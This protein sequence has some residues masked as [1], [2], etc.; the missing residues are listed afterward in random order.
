M[1]NDYKKTN[2]QYL[3]S[4]YGYEIVEQH[5]DYEKNEIEKEI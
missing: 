3:K 1:W 2:P 4:K 5:Y